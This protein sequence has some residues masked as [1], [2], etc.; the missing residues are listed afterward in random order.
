MAKIGLGAV[1]IWTCFLG[2]K[3]SLAQ[4][5][6][7]A[8]P[9][10]QQALEGIRLRRGL[11][12][13]ARGALAASPADFVKFY[14]LPDSSGKKVELVLRHQ[15]EMGIDALRALDAEAAVD[16]FVEVRSKE[17]SA[18]LV[19]SKFGD[20]PSKE[21]DLQRYNDRMNSY[22]QSSAYIDD[23]KEHVQQVLSHSSMIQEEKLL[24]IEAIDQLLETANKE[25]R[26]HYK[27]GAFLSAVKANDMMGNREDL[28]EIFLAM[29]NQEAQA[30]GLNFWDRRAVEGAFED[31]FKHA[32][33]GYVPVAG[34]VVPQQ[35]VPVQRSF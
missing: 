28:R 27:L 21:K 14:V 13:Y 26:A 24:E 2:T 20:K 5:L 11:Y 17:I 34:H 12:N 7:S 10:Q 22:L 19:K 33:R 25:H 6:V 23:L 18:N 31:G 29:S 16:S 15:E 9:L 1:L 30:R 3:V 35:Q 4:G 32:Q 8:H